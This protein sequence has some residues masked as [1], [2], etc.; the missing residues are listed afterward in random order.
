MD[1]RFGDGGFKKGSLGPETRVVT[2]AFAILF[3]VRSSEVLVLPSNAS[4]A[5]GN[6]GFAE[7]VRI[8]QS[9]K[10]T[11]QAPGGRSGH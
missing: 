2:T 8:R 1:K 6:Q 10:G 4:R 11:V 3:L 9:E 5:N 7:N